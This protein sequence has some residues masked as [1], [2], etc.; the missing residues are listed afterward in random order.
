MRTFPRC[1]AFSA[2]L[3]LLACGSS[4]SDTPPTPP[5]P[6]AG[7]SAVAG[8]GE[9]TLTWTAS[10]GATEYT[11]YYGV[12]PGVRKTTGTRFTSA[13]SPQVLGGL[14]D[15]VTYHFVVTAS[16]PGGESAESNEVGA[17]PAATF[18]QAAFAGDW[19]VLQFRTNASPGWFWAHA[20]LDGSGQIE[21]LESL[22]SD[23]STALP[24]AGFDLRATVDA[25][26][27]VRLEGADGDPSFH[28]SMTSSRTL[29]FATATELDP[30]LAAVVGMDF[31]VWRRR[32]PG[33]TFGTAD[34][35]GAAFTFHAIY[36]GPGFRWEYGAGSV[37]DAG[38][39]SVTEIRD[40]LG[41]TTPPGT[42]GEVAVDA[43]GRV[44][45]PGTPLL[46]VM[47][48]DKNAVF[49]VNTTGD[50]GFPEP[51]LLVLLRS[52]QAF[53]PADLAGLYDFHV[54]Q[55]GEFAQTSYWLHGTLGV[56]PAS[57]VTFSAFGNSAGVT[58]L[59]ASFSLAL[60]ASGVVLR[61]GDTTFHGQMSRG[62][63]F[64]VR[65]SGT[66]SSPGFGV[67][68]R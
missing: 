37:D 30:D 10:P 43:A 18:T 5:T 53:V 7:L 64:Y 32:V 20:R 29:V 52:G 57:V 39:F 49:L 55:S 14:L 6:P 60:S 16:G 51:A 47:A 41:N 21:V 28:G 56:D 33:V 19:D 2:V 44:T 58:A 42:I 12:S 59:P 1:I 38:V 17:T 15:G 46:G 13:A 8:D 31:F 67:V 3:V 35:V 68:A 40:A 9:V 62:K 54:V 63:D 34:V 27:T 61:P 48:A 65:T 45:M 24:P 22:D 66:A 11:A 50:P 36:S 4:G 23:G 26:G 25:A